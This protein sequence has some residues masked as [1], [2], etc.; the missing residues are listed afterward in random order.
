MLLVILLIERTIISIFKPP[1]K[2]ILIAEISIACVC[3]VIIMLNRPTLYLKVNNDCEWFGIYYT[4]SQI[5]NETE[6]IF[7]NDKIISIKPNDVLFLSKDNFEHS[8]KIVE[9]IDP[10]WKNSLLYDKE[11]D[12][13]EKGF[14]SIYIRSQE[15]PGDTLIQSV[16]TIIAKS[17]R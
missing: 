4:A 7:P 8:L 9:T 3:L 2:N 11:Y 16:R 17:V 14:C 12:V 1:V 5:D 10:K 15:I 6:Y 13:G